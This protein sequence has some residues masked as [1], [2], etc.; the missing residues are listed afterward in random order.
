MSVN[1]SLFVFYADEWKNFLERIGVKDGDVE[2][3]KQKMDEIRFWV[4]YRGQTLSRTG[5]LQVTSWLILSILA[6]CRLL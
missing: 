2:A 6:L 3:L 4:S 5:N 1:G